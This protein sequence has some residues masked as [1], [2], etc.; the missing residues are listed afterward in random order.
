LARLQSARPLEDSRAVR[1]VSRSPVS[2]EPTIDIVIPCHEKDAWILPRAISGARRNVLHRI[3]SVVVVAP[4]SRKIQSVCRRLDCEFVLEDVAAPLPR[5]DVN[6]NVNGR[7][8]SGWIYQQ[9][10]KLSADRVSKAD[11]ILVLDADTVLIRPHVFRKCE[12]TILFVTP[13]GRGNYC[14][15]YARLLA[16]PWLHSDSFI[17]HYMLLE[18]QKLAELR[19]AIEAVMKQPWYSAI[20]ATADAATDAS[21]F[22]EYETYG[23]FCLV[24]YVDEFLLERADNL[25]LPPSW[26]ATLPLIVLAGRWRSVSLHHYAESE[27][28]RIVLRRVLRSFVSREP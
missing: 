2:G 4:E 13:E 22:S 20:L 7:D 27:D 25:A 19:D 24:N 3:G 15:A 11:Y 1:I 9:L 23:N 21:F 5:R 17:T 28:R 18:R 16:L 10:I 12:Q 6:C 8:C 26:I 14:A